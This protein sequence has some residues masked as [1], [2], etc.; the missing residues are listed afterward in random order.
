MI[1]KCQCQRCGGAIEFDVAEFQE[2]GRDAKDIFGQYVSC[3]HCGAETTLSM[4]NFATPNPN[5]HKEMLQQKSIEAAK[6]EEQQNAVR[7]AEGRAIIR[8]FRLLFW[9]AVI[10]VIFWWIFLKPSQSIPTAFENPSQPQPQTFPVHD[11]SAPIS[12]PKVS[13][14]NLNGQIQ[15]YGGMDITG[16]IHNLSGVALDGVSVNFSFLDDDGNKVDDAMDFIQT[17]APDDAWSFKVSSL[18]DSCKKYRLDNITSFIDN[19]QVNLD[20][21]QTP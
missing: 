5:P 14:S 20:V 9:L 21:Q 17:L 2:T 1:A 19:S 6:V 18:K 8:V 13:I 10:A 7:D 12:L 15:D 16:I 4:P 3:P 11:A